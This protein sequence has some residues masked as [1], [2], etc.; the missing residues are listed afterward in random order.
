MKKLATLL[1]VLSLTLI[2]CF[3]G[4][5]DDCFIVGNQLNGDT[6]AAYSYFMRPPAGQPS[7]FISDNTLSNTGM[8]QGTGVFAVLDSSLIYDPSTETLKVN[9]AIIPPARSFN[10]APSAKTIQT[11]AASANGFQVSSSRDASVNY[12]VTIVSSTTILGATNVSG[13]VVIEVA[14]TNSSTAADW[15]ELGRTPNGQNNSLTIAVGTL[16]S[17]GGG[18]LGCVVPS[19]YYCRLRSINVAGTPTYTYNSGQEVLL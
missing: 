6:T 3:A 8:A 19:G 9:P 15:K 2:R 10:N 4:L 16:T 13:Y 17:T 14:A 5:Y 12:S 11:V 7:V 18:Q 1:A